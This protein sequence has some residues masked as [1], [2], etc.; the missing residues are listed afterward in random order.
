MN[1]HG[2]EP[3]GHQH[4]DP[5]PSASV[6]NEGNGYLSAQIAS[7]S[8]TGSSLPLHHHSRDLVDTEMARSPA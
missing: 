8:T 7:F 2:P 5:K 3:P 6:G 4:V 1:V